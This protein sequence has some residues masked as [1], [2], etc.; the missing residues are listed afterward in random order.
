MEV[1]KVGEVVSRRPVRSPQRNSESEKHYIVRSIERNLLIIY[2]NLPCLK[3]S[4]N[5]ILVWEKQSGKSMP[6]T[7]HAV[8]K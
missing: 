6:E 3:I 5:S 8:T 1:G 2:Y 7:F 4:W